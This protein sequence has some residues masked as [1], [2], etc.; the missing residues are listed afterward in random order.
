MHKLENKITEGVCVLQEQAH[1]GSRFEPCLDSL[2]TF[3]SHSRPHSAQLLGPGVISLLKGC[4]LMPQRS[5]ASYAALLSA[6][7]E[8]SY[9]EESLKRGRGANALPQCVSRCMR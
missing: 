2:R 4:H 9:G 6:Q 8:L 5:H 7:S 3:Q 1:H